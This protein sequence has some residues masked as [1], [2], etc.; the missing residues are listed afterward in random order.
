MEYGMNKC[1][2]TNITKGTSSQ[3]G[4]IPCDIQLLAG[5]NT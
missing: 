4:E 2:L 5:T 1:A 3:N